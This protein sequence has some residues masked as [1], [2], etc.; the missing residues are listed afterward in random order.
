MLELLMPIYSER[1]QHATSSELDVKATQ[2]LESRI[3]EHVLFLYAQGAIEVESDDR[4]LEAFFG[5]A[6]SEA[7]ASALGR[8][9]WHVER[10]DA[11]T[12]EVI[13]LDFKNFGSGGIM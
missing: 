13:I 7:R 5:N 12:T 8:L 11:P 3:G 9:G 1:L 4:L 6:S 10:W 2:T